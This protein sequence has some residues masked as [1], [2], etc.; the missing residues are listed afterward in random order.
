M[1]WGHSDSGAVK[2][3]AAVAGQEASCR[4][5][6]IICTLR[7]GIIGLLHNK[8][9]SE[10]PLPAPTAITRPWQPP[11]NKV[12][13]LR[14]VAPCFLADD[15]CIQEQKYHSTH[16]ALQYREYTRVHTHKTMNKSNLSLIYR[17]SG[18]Q[19]PFSLFCHEGCTALARHVPIQPSW[20]SHQFLGGHVPQ[21]AGGACAVK[22]CKKHRWGKRNSTSKCFHDKNLQEEDTENNNLNFWASQH[23]IVFLR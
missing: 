23:F 1:R 19:R 15:I 14:L 21:S 10:A 13:G 17:A 22:K 18:S 3:L 7:V 12:E 20:H 5:Q 11:L 8:C 9:F 6:P 16:E 2:A 4:E